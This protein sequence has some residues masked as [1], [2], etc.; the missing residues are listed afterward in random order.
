VTGV[1]DVLSKIN[2]LEDNWNRTYAPRW[3]RY[4]QP[5]PL[6]IGTMRLPR[7]D[8]SFWDELD[9]WTQTLN[10]PQRQQTFSYAFNSPL[11]ATD[12]DG[13]IVRGPFFN[14]GCG[15]RMAGVALAAARQLSSKP[16]D[17][18]NGF[19]DAYRHCA[20]NCLMVRNCG[21]PTAF[22]VATGYELF[23]FPWNPPAE[24]NMDLHN[25]A[26]GR[27]CGDVFCDC[28]ACCLGKLRAGDLVRLR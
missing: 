13:R 28:H 2:A 10:Q 7:P 25:N 4:T 17:L 19:A 5:D 1:T 26:K 20:W 6:N 14:T 16:E 3:G 23:R 9:L 27:E 21:G 15:E 8:V 22:T 12:P 24:Q 11:S 18:H